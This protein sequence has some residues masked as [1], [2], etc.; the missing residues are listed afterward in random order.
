MPPTLA[1]D[2]AEQLLDVTPLIMRRIRAEMRRRTMGGLTVPHF[3]ALNYLRR[4]PR[5]SLN[6]VA[7]YLGLTAPST[8]KLVQKLVAEKAVARRVGADRRRVCLSL[9]QTGITALAVA[10]AETRE[11][12]ADNL[13]S[14][15]EEELGA[16]SAAL[17]V[18]GEAF[19]KGGGSGNVL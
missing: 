10:R 17:R 18:L 8:S 9:T 16:V 19:S 14:L 5:A 7:G 13:K 12:L 6:D 1:S 4:H 2:C 15:S 3:R 11:H